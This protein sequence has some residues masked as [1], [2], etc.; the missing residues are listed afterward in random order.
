MTA[1]QGVNNSRR[2]PLTRL[3]DQRFASVPVATFSH[4]GR[5]GAGKEMKLLHAR[6]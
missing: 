4:E 1:G 6:Y 5:R 3:A 2:I